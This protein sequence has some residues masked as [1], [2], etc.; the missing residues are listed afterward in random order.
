MYTTRNFVYNSDHK[1][2]GNRTG[3]KNIEDW[4][5]DI[6]SKWVKENGN[7]PY[8]SEDD[9][10]RLAEE[11]NLSI[12]QVSNWFTNARKVSYYNH[13]TCLFAKPGLDLD[14]HYFSTQFEII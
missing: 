10:E 2:L 9:K 8:P 11:C 13:T 5:K 1:R 14:W 12:K 6:L 4:K 3:Q 7:N